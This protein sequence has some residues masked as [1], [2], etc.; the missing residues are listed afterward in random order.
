[1]A[2]NTTVNVIASNAIQTEAI[3]YREEYKKSHISCINKT[4]T[5]S[6]LL[7]GYGLKLATTQHRYSTYKCCNL[8]WLL[9]LT[10]NEDIYFVLDTSTKN[11]S[12]V[13]FSSVFFSFFLPLYFT[14]LCC[15]CFPKDT[16][17]LHV[18]NIFEPKANAQQLKKMV[19]VHFFY[20]FWASISF[21]HVK[22]ASFHEL[23]FRIPL[24]YCQ[25]I[26][27]VTTTTQITHSMPLIYIYD[28]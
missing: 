26:Y 24:H 25:H 3:K 19:Q 14:I 8:L 7:I 27:I 28:T 23:S 20:D 5:E 2:F 17:V 4:K 11:M 10:E 21:M 9:R 6:I 12:T 16:R 13:V 18:V 1:M 15:E 22:N